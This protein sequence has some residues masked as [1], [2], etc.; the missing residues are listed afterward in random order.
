MNFSVFP[1]MSFLEHKHRH[2]NLFSNAYID[3]YETFKTTV[4]SWSVIERSESVPL[5]NSQQ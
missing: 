2:K 1:L 5:R 4:K 3:P